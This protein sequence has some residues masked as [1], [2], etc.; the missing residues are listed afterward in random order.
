MDDGL[1]ISK[2]A[3]YTII[4]LERDTQ[5]EKHM[6]PLLIVFEVT[7]GLKNNFHK[8]QWDVVFSNPPVVVERNGMRSVRSAKARGVELDLFGLGMSARGP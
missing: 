4:F 6:K 8:F 7:S 5:Q 2:Y 3:D 1:S